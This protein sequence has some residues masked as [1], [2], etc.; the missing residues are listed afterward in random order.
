MISFNSYQFY[1]LSLTFQFFFCFK[2]H[3]KQDVHLIETILANYQFFFMVNTKS[4]TDAWKLLH[5]SCIYKSMMKSYSGLMDSVTR[6]SEVLY[7]GLQCGITRRLPG[8]AGPLPRSC[9]PEPATVAQRS[10]CPHSNPFLS[11]TET[12]KVK[13]TDYYS[14]TWL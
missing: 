13:H 7:S 8:V 1:N 12:L 4:I 10:P 11:V 9:P 3:L 6:Y 2:H 14:R 5:E